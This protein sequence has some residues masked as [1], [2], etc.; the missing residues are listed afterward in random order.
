MAYKIFDW[1]LREKSGHTKQTSDFLRE[2]HAKKLDIEEFVYQMR[3]I[4][5]KEGAKGKTRN[6]SFLRN[7]YKRLQN[8]FGFFL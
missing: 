3:L 1:E 2:N 5:K 8:D 7:Q 4:P 6:P